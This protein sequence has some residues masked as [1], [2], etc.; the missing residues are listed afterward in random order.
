MKKVMGICLLTALM[1]ANVFAGGGNS[2]ATASSTL[3]LAAPGSTSTND[4]V[5]T[6]AYVQGEMITSSGATW[7][8]LVAGTTGATAPSGLTDFTDGTV[9]WRRVLKRDRVGLFIANEGSVR[10]TIS[11]FSN[12]IVGEGI[13]LAAGEKVLFT[14]E[15]TPQSAVHV[16]TDSSTSAVSILEW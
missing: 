16:I 9:V 1:S 11:W 5:T 3:L 12:V 8:A 15:D 7:F 2:D 14:L 4:W 6:T 13:T 10:V